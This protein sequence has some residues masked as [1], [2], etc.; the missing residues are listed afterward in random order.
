MTETNIPV[1]NKQKYNKP[2][3]ITNLR[4][5]YAKKWDKHNY[6]IEFEVA[7]INTSM[8]NAIRRLMISDVKTVGF[9][10]EPYK[11]CNL[12]VHV[13]DT[14]LHNQFVLHRISM[15]PIYVANPDKFDCDDYLFI[16]DMSNNTNSIINITSEHFQ[17]KCIC[18]QKN[19]I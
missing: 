11:A 7:N 9:R 4:Y 19:N 5:P 18:L 1:E 6:S 2:N 13:N 16:I 10:T 15:I 14:P 17:I 12:H 3:Y 8:A